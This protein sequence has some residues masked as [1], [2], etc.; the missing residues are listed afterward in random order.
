MDYSAH[1]HMSLTSISEGQHKIIIN[2]T[3]E[4]ILDKLS[5]Q[6]FLY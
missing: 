5:N 4:I 1:F 3:H 2:T 6:A